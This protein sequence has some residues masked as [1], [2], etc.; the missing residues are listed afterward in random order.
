MISLSELAKDPRVL[1]QVVF[2]AEEH[3][4]VAAAFGPAPNGLPAKFRQLPAP[5]Q[6]KESQ[7]TDAALRVALRVAGRYRS[8][9]WRD[10]LVRV[11]FEHLRDALPAD[12][13]V[14]NDL[15][16]LPLAQSLG[17]PRTVFDAHEHWTSES[18][19]WSWRQRLSM[20]GAH[21]WIVDA[22]V[23]TTD[24]IMTVSNGIADEYYGRA[25]IR[26]AIVTNAP[27]FQDLRPSPTGDALRLV[28]LGIADERRRLE[29]TI[30]AVRALDNRF[31]LDLVLAR[32]NDYRR[33]LERLASAAGDRIRVLPPVAPADMVSFANAYDVGVFLLPERFPNQVHVLPNKLFEYIQARLAVA[34]GPSPEMARIVREWNCGVVASSFSVDD[35]AMALSTLTA[36]SV[37]TMKANA[38][39][40]AHALTAEANR[41]TVLA[42]VREGGGEADDADR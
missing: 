21:E 29:D 30:E 12:V 36:E 1:R 26:P 34:I 37:D 35:F 8:A 11:W 2:L 32:D 18:A 19:S 14:V 10:P 17:A 15:A 9:Y 22:C 27:F 38:D 5:A 39:R 40:A 42:L 41:E 6:T 4:V 13:V 28:H 33:R 25:G 24:V 23:P 20:R 3:D 16:A 31:R 7:R